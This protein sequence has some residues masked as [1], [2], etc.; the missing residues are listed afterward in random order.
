[1][2][3]NQYILYIIYLVF[4][5]IDTLYVYILSSRYYGPSMY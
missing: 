4:E 2:V 1:M 3:M 5:G